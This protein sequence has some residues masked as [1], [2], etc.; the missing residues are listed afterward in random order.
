MQK[1][2]AQPSQGLSILELLLVLLVI[3]AMVFTGVSRYQV[4]RRERDVSIIRENVAILYQALLL[5]YATNCTWNYYSVGMA[6]FNIQSDPNYTQYQALLSKLIFIPMAPS[7]LNYAV[8]AEQLNPTPP[9]SELPPPPPA[10]KLFVQVKLLV[11][12]NDVNLAWFRQALETQTASVDG[13][14]A[15]QLTFTRMPNF[16]APNPNLANPLWLS[17]ENL[18]YFKR[19]NRIRGQ[20]IP[21]I[22]AF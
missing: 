20:D 6:S 18:Q 16:G 14:R 5:H 1:H 19:A 9:P 15:I 12:A 4:Y 10:Y 11:P 22:C 3:A 8:N 2:P 7:I 21:G 17:H 13:G